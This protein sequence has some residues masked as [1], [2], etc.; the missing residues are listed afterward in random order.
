MAMTSRRGI[1][2][3][4]VVTLIAIAAILIGC[5]GPYLVSSRENARLPACRVNLKWFG[6]ALHNYHDTYN[7]WPPLRGGTAGG[8]Q[9]EMLSGVAMLLPFLDEDP[10]W[11]EIHNFGGGVSA[12]G[13]Q[14]G[15]PYLATFPHP[16]A[17]LEVFLCPSSYDAILINAIGHPSGSIHRSYVF[18]VG[19]TIN[20]NTSPRSTRRPAS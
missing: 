1:S 9:N 8:S 13:D 12:G 20:D 18:S 14:G 19:D 11:Q 2:Q 4:E 7:C 17:E 6:L 16:P 5:G 15:S 10:H 3:V